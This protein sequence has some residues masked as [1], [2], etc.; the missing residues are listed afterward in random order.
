MKTHYETDQWRNRREISWLNLSLPTRI[1]AH[2]EDGIKNNLKWLETEFRRIQRGLVDHQGDRAL[3]NRL[4]AA[5]SGITELEFALYRPAETSEGVLNDMYGA[6]DQKSLSKPSSQYHQRMN[7]S[8]PTNQNDILMADRHYNTAPDF[9]RQRNKNRSSAPLTRGSNDMNNNRAG[10]KQSGKWIKKCLICHKINCWSTNHPKEERQK[11]FD[12]IKQRYP[13]KPDTEIRQF[14]MEIEGER[15]EVSFDNFLTDFESHLETDLNYD[16]DDEFLQ[17]GNLIEEIGGE[18]AVAYLNDQ[19]IFH[20]FTA[21]NLNISDRSKTQIIF[22]DSETSDLSVS[23][24]TV[25]DLQDIPTNEIKSLESTYALGNLSLNRYDDRIFHGLLIDTGAA[26][27]STVGIGQFRALQRLRKNLKLDKTQAGKVN[28]SG[29]G[30]GVFASIGAVVL[31]TPIGQISFHLVPCNIPFLLG[32]SDMKNFGATPDVVN[33]KMLKHG[34][35]VAQLFEKYGHL[36]MT[37]GYFETLFLY[38]SD[39]PPMCLL[40]EQELR[41]IHR[42]WGHPSATRMWKILSRAGHETE[43]HTIDR[44]T[45]FCRECQLNSNRP[46]R[47]KFALRKDNEFNHT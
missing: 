28:I 15:P 43:L 17:S 16:S 40:T 23:N 42:R 6:L 37:L 8:E 38:E 22:V 19:A 27:R 36:W 33:N 39:E 3:R 21:P 7:Y 1:A 41:T 44:L 47:F 14:V 12:R 24:S 32:L 11:A 30:A 45:K 35:T 10:P 29:I 18:N 2:P 20:S 5:C 34:K 9:G 46:L 4:V 25:F 13:Q 26:G 31:D